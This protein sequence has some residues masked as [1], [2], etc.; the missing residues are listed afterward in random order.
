MSDLIRQ[1]ER[2]RVQVQEQVVYTYIRMY[3][4]TKWDR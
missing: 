1:Q 2:V 3:V 4:C